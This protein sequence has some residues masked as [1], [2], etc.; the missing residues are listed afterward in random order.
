MFDGNDE[1]FHKWEIQWNAFAQ[2]EDN[3]R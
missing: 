3:A 1:L 2:V